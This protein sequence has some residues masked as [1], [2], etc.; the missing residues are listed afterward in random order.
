MDKF[1]LYTE[2]SPWFILLCLLTGFAYAYFLYQKKSPWN[3]TTNRIL[4]TLRFLLVSF[5]CFLLIGPLIRYIRNYIE[6]PTIVLAI[7]NSQSIS[8]AEDSLSIESLKKS[9]HQLSNELSKEDIKV[10]VQLFDKNIPAGQIPEV[11]FNHPSSNLSRILQDIESD[12]EN[13]NLA[14]VVLVSDGIYNQGISPSYNQYSYP[15]FPVALGDTVP[16]KDLSIRTALYNKISYQG[17]KFPLVAEIQNNGFAGEKVNVFLKQNG[18]I[19]QNQSFNL[20]QNSELN[21]IEF[22]HASESKGLQHYVIEVEALKGEFTL[23]NNSYHVYI[24]IIEGKESVLIVALTPHPDIKA[25]KSALESKENYEVETYIPG[26]TEFKDSKYDLVI[27]HQIPDNGG[28]AKNL[29]DKFLNDETSVLFIAGNQSNHSTLNNLNRL[30]KINFRRGQF[31]N[32]TPSYNPAFEKFKITPE[33]QAVINSWPPIPVPFADFEIKENSD[34]ILFQK[35][36]SVTSTKPLFLVNS[37]NNKKTGIL[38]GEGLWEWKLAEFN[39]N[40]NSQVFEKLIGNIVQFLSTKEDK[41]KFRVYPVQNEFFISDRI[42]FETEIYNDIFEKVYGQKIDLKITG[43]DGKGNSYSYVNSENGSLFEVKG[44]QPGIYKYSATTTLA[45]KLQKSEGEF[46]VKE[47]LLEALQTTADHR[48]LRNIANQTNGGFYFPSEV[49]SLTTYLKENRAK[50]IIHSNE[51]FVELINLN[52]LF[53]LILA[54]ASTEWFIRR[55]K[56]GY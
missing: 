15:V 4:F 14:G 8:L 48:L 46:T 20:K 36:G 40:K 1:S 3:L 44:L 55:Y 13:R 31:D 47:I 16:K 41:R 51:E 30:V 43:E 17:N 10:N 50:S 52:W 9:L 37:T 24:D 32:V 12:F 34:I 25:I 53:F 45:G 22:I 28:T 21:Q 2:Y 19:L 42:L 18:R 35:I 7:D 11:K 29:L 27:F 56:G 26:I 6:N 33:E 49:S 39:A 54:L 38:I 23:K 5:L